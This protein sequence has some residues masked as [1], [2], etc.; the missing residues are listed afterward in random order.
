LLAATTVPSRLASAVAATRTSPSSSFV[1]VE[2]AKSGG[3]TIAVAIASQPPISLSSAAA[4]T[5]AQEFSI[6][7]IQPTAL[8]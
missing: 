8:S 3:P 1:P 5:Q 4:P 2:L 6:Q 7:T